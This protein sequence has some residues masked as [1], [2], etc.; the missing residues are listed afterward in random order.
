MT[1][2]CAHVVGSPVQ[3]EDTRR[4]LGAL[5]RELVQECGDR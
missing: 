5:S 1:E 3:Q 2:L 4:F